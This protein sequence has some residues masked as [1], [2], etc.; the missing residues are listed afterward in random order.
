[1]ERNVTAQQL[2]DALVVVTPFI[3]DILQVDMGFAVTDKEKF[4]IQKDGKTLKLNISP[5]DPLKPTS[6]S[7]EAMRTKKYAVKNM[8]ASLYGL[9]VRLSGYP[10]IDENNNVIGSVGIARNI[11]TWTGLNNSAEEL[12]Q[13]SGE[14][15]SIIKLFLE[16]ASQ[17]KSESEALQEKAADI[18][19]KF[20]RSSQ[21]LDSIKSIASQTRLIG[22]NAAIEAA[23]IGDV[24]RGFGVVADEIRKLSGHSNDASIEI[25]KT[26]ND[27]KI[28]LQ[29]ITDEVTSINNTV[30][31]QLEKAKEI[32][33]RIERFEEI[34]KLLLQLSSKL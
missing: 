26:L 10:I 17:I 19:N 22:L 32:N 31:S 6:A 29:S 33:T 4:I 24:G 1:M 14:V 28:D 34:S 13:S 21:I 20:K 12:S 3:A 16:I 7:A 5:G 25:E 18:N 23:R 27:L 9:P 2:M 30:I 15:G 8:D 11:E